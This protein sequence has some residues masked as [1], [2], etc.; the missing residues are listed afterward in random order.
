MGFQKKMGGGLTSVVQNSF[1]K[2]VQ[3]NI[4]SSP[5]ADLIAV[6]LAY[7]QDPKSPYRIGPPRASRMQCPKP[8]GESRMIERHCNSGPIKLWHF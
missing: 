3:I 5:D 4:L 6:S 2:G 1:D 7:P 8:P